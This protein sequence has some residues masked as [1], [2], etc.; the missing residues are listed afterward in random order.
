M[1]QWLDNDFLPCVGH[2]FQFR[3]TP[4]PHW[5]GVTDCEVL[6]LEPNRRLVVTAGIRSG[7]QAAVGVN[8]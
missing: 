3:A 2:K 1:T 6:A 7:A 5:N 4:T 8:T